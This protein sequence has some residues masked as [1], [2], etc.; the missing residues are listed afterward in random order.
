MWMN[1]FFE[2]IDR[3]SLPA[4]LNLYVAWFEKLCTLLL[5][6]ATN[7]TTTLYWEPIL[8]PVD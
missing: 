7:M 2:N 5:I 8:P 6:R 4:I 3:A 1:F